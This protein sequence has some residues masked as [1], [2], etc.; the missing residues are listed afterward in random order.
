M[1][2]RIIKVKGDMF[3]I[4]FKLMHAHP[5]SL[6]FVAKNMDNDG[7]KMSSKL[8]SSKGQKQ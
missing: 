5:Y 2:A 3:R 4:A 1:A 6:S 8:I 7:H